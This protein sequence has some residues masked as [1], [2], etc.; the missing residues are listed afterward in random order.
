MTYVIG[1]NPARK[2]FGVLV[3]G[4]KKMG[5]D[6]LRFQVSGPRLRS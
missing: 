2:K 4:H 3:A 6:L 1:T 5:T